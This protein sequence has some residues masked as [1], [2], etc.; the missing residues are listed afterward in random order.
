MFQPVTVETLGPLS[1]S[2]LNS[3]SEV[4]RRLTSRNISRITR[5]LISVPAPPLSAY[6]ALQLCSDY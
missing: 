1:A 3:L 6:T 4:G 2:A 5:D